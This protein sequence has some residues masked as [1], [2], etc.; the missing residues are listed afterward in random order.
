MNYERLLNQDLA[1]DKCASVEYDWYLVSI[2]L[3]LKT[4]TTN[5][6]QLHIDPIV[7]ESTCKIKS[8]NYCPKELQ[9]NYMG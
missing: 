8:S 7:L 4:Q 6:K 2:V 3:F 1:C 9:S 5:T